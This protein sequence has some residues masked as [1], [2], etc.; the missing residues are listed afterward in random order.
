MEYGRAGRSSRLLPAARTHKA[1]RQRPP[2]SSRPVR[3]RARIE[4]WSSS[5][6][7][8]REIWTYDTSGN[9]TSHTD[10]RGNKTTYACNTS[11]QLTTFTDLLGSALSVIRAS[12]ISSEHLK[13]S[14]AQARH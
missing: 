1:E 2:R 13:A 5:G 11:N 7:G 9:I 4:S 6:L 14:S 8:Y 10:G 3:S 12:R